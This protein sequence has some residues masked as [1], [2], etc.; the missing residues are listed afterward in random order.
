[1]CMKTAE[2][3]TGLALFAMVNGVYG[4]AVVSAIGQN[5]KLR[6]APQSGQSTVEAPPSLHD[7]LDVDLAA[8]AEGPVLPLRFLVDDHYVLRVETGVARHASHDVREDLAL[9]FHAAP[10]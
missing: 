1:M 2:R 3:P 5:R 7:W 9:H 6:S 8:A 10:D 4:P